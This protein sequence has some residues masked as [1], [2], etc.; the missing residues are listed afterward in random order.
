M[1]TISILNYNL[2]KSEI[3]SKT[4]CIVNKSMDN[5]RTGVDPFNLGGT[6]RVLVK[7]TYEVNL[8]DVFFLQNIKFSYIYLYC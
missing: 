6:I 5:T 7:N 2:N 4:L 3:N 8:F 1:K